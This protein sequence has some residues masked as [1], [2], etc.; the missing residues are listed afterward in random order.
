MNEGSNP[1][2]GTWRE[3]GTKNEQQG[4][5]SYYPKFKKIIMRL[6]NILS[7]SI[8]TLTSMNIKYNKN[9]MHQK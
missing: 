8:F 4:H 1:A 6:S 5:R 9:K 2:I 7:I 3:E